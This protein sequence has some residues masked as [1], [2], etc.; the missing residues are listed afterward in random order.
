[1]CHTGSHPAACSTGSLAPSLAEHEASIALTL[2]TALPNPQEQGQ[3]SKLE[4]Q[5][6]TLGTPA[7]VATKAVSEMAARGAC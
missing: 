3:E 2:L 6:G 7:A 1:M 5:T 4:G